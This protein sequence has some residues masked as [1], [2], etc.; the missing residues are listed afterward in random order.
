M[1]TVLI[2]AFEPYERW[3][4]NASWLTLVHLTQSLPPAPEVTTR[5]LPVDFERVKSLLAEELAA[6]Y[7]YALHLGQA[8]GRARIE[9]EAVALNVARNHDSQS[10]RQLCD[11]GPLSYRTSLPLYEWASRIRAVGIPAEVSFHA[12][13]FLCNAAM[14][15]THYYVE[16]MGLRT[17]AAFVHLP[18]DTSQVTGESGEMPSLPAVLSAGA[19]RIILELI[20]RDRL[21][22]STLA[23]AP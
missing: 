10:D 19:I 17:Q 15:M 1:A 18:L 3:P 14:Y 8:P 7:D 11:D 21:A 22:N 6:D 4:T 16:R 9:L 13:T 12:G 5:L 2:T 20:E 23:Q